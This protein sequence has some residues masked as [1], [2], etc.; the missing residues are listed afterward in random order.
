MRLLI[1]RRLGAAFFFALRMVRKF[2]LSVEISSCLSCSVLIFF[3]I[4]SVSFVFL[5]NRSSNYQ[6]KTNSAKAKLNV[7]AYAALFSSAEKIYN[8]TGF[9]LIPMVVLKTAIG[10]TVELDEN[11]IVYVLL[12]GVKQNVHTVTPNFVKAVK[13][14]YLIVEEPENVERLLLQMVVKEERD[15]AE[16]LA[17]EV[18]EAN[19]KEQKKLDDYEFER[20]V[21]EVI[22]KISIVQTNDKP[23][24]KPHVSFKKADTVLNEL[25][26]VVRCSYDGLPSENF[27]SL[28]LE[29]W[30][31]ADVDPQIAYAK[32][33]DSVTKLRN[34]H[35]IVK[36]SGRGS[37]PGSLNV[38]RIQ[39][40]KKR[41]KNSI[42][43]RIRV[44]FK[45]PIDVYADAYTITSLFGGM[46]L[47]YA[48]QLGVSAV[49]EDSYE[50][51]VLSYAVTTRF[52]KT[53]AFVNGIY[54]LIPMF[55]PHED[56]GAFRDLADKL[57]EGLVET[58]EVL[59]QTENSKAYFSPSSL[60]EKINYLVS[61]LP[62]EFVDFM[63]SKAMVDRCRSWLKIHD[64]NEREG[65]M[66][67]A[68]SRHLVDRVQE[69]FQHHSKRKESLAMDLGP[70]AEGAGKWRGR[71]SYEFALGIIADYHLEP[72]EANV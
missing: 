51:S 52:V 60:Y 37:E 28:T 35:A 41:L 2:T 48:R 3:R 30:K 7:S 64:A 34:G 27:P 66:I 72:R 61:V 1:F 29:S 17:M 4:V 42:P 32:I 55:Q 70:L 14:G 5:K 22:S 56:F 40:H 15:S 71:V 18:E 24:E 12:E 8:Q 54:P 31:D 33:R 59:I 45:R 38:A 47:E 50:K 67:K 57:E 46:I 53:E 58:K 68:E 44:N 11:S 13:D 23:P 16:I 63:E 62:V 19:G 10:N 26:T 21:W 20:L 39:S 9:V 36:I 65:R 43:K 69:V 49:V 25:E 6:N